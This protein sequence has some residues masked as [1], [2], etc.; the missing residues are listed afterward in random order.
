[1]DGKGNLIPT[2]IVEKSLPFKPEKQENSL[3]FGDHLETKYSAEL[4]RRIE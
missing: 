3:T 1:M 4:F 2:N